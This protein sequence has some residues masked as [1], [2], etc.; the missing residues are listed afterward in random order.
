MNNYLDIVLMTINEAKKILQKKKRSHND[1]VRGNALLEELKESK[2]IIK[3]KVETE[4]NVSVETK[5]EITLFFQKFDDYYCRLNNRKSI[6]YIVQDC[7]KS[8]DVP[9]CKHCSRYMQNGC[10]LLLNN[11]Y[12]VDEMCNIWRR[13]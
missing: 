3:S 10:R 8:R 13:I 1:I 2:K 12:T 11:T 5:K 7:L 9:N 6:P 4:G